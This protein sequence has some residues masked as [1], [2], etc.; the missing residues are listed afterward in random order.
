MKFKKLRPIEI[1]TL[2]Y[3]V[4]NLIIILGGWKKVINPHVHFP[5]F[6]GIGIVLLG[7]N[8]WYEFKPYKWLM[9]VRD[10]YPV[11]LFVYLFEA[12]SN[13]NRILFSDFIDPFFQRIDFWIFGNQPALVWGKVLDNYFWQEL[14]HFAYFSYYLIPVLFIF[15]YLRDKE[16]Y[17]K[18]AFTI[19]FT[20]FVCYL[21]YIFLPVIGGRWWEIMEGY[22]S[23]TTQYRYGI[24]TRIMA[25]IYSTTSHQGGAFPSSHVAVSIVA[26]IIAF[27]YKKL[28]GWILVP[29]TILIAISTVHCHY[30]YFIDTI[31]GVLYGFGFY[32]L[33][34]KLYRRMLKVEKS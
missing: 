12:T 25:F 22:P 33:G 15:V 31:F 19:T 29:V 1:I 23:L 16:L 20:F 18:L 5:V 30:H 34:L 10:W 4:I 28:V 21:T 9:I 3:I 8:K 32:F 26:N 11:T 6:L 13:L 7:I 2:S 17:L 24:F 14:F 27:E